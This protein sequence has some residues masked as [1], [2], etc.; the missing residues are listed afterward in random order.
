MP[1]CSGNSFKVLNLSAQ[2]DVDDFEVV[3]GYFLSTSR[4]L[5]NVNDELAL[6]ATYD[7]REYCVDFVHQVS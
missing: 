5:V 6:T 3:P 1:E 7:V 4:R 2:I